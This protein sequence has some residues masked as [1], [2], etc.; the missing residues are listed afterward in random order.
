LNKIITKEVGVF[1]YLLLTAVAMA[2]MTFQY[3]GHFWF[4][5]IFF[6]KVGDPHFLFYSIIYFSM[7]NHFRDLKKILAN[8]KNSVKK[9]NL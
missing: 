8:F 4:K 3:G 7:L 5:V 6:E 9:S 1:K 2:M